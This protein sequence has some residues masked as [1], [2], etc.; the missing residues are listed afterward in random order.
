M[1]FT[2][3]KEGAGNTTVRAAI[4]PRGVA[5]KRRASFSSDTFPIQRQRGTCSVCK[6]H[7]SREPTTRLK[8]VQRK[9]NENGKNANFVNYKKVYGSVRLIR[10]RLTIGPTTDDDDDEITFLSFDRFADVYSDV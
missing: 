4:V 1:A 10:A 8:G 2:D 9:R 5:Q 6:T 3:E 7:I